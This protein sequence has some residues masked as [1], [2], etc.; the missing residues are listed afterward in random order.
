MMMD[1]KATITAPLMLVA[2]TLFW[3]FSFPVMKALSIEQVLLVPGSSSLLTSSAGLIARY[4]AAALVLLLLSAR[5]IHRGTM[6]EAVHGMILGVF[7]GTGAFFQLD[8]LTYTSASASAF[9]T[10]SYALLVPLFLAMYNRKWPG[11][12]IW[13]SCLLVVA[14]I[15]ILSGLRPGDLSPGRGEWETLAASVCFTFQILWMQRVDPARDN[16]IHVTLVLCLVVALL[17]VVPALLLADRVPDLLVMHSSLRAGVLVILLAILSTAIPFLLMN[18]YQPQV[19]P[20]AAGIIYCAEPVFASLLAIVL[21]ALLVRE[22]SFYHN[23]RITISLA[24]G[25]LLITAANLLIQRRG[26]ETSQQ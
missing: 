10:S 22:P 26:A 9:I 13:L 17:Q 8:G 21:P 18:R 5:T 12:R 19:T 7:I 16:P 20:V 23:E 24:A 3:G 2:A 11:M 14:G 1:Q 4:G 15:G 25:G 6:R